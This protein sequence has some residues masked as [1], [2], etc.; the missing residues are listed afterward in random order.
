MII[1]ATIVLPSGL[2]WENELTERPVATASRRTVTGDEVVFSTAVAGRDIDLTSSGT[3]G[4][5]T[6]ADAEQIRALAAVPG[7]EYPLY[8]RGEKRTVRF[9]WEEPDAVHF[10]PVVQKTEYAADDR[11]VGRIRLREV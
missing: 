6:Y 7:A 1:L 2:V 8:L 9:R 11:F 3:S 10:L 5:F 4:W